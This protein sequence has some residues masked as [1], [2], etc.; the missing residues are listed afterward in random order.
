MLPAAPPAILFVGRL[1]AENPGGQRAF[2]EDLLGAA[3]VLCEARER[4]VE[5][6][7]PRPGLAPFE[8]P[9]VRE[10]VL[11]SAGGSGPLWT[12]LAVRPYANRQRHCVLY[13]PEGGLPV[14]LRIPGFVA[15]GDL[16]PFPQAGGGNLWD[17]P[18]WEGVYRRWAMR[19]AVRQSP[20]VHCWSEAVAEQARALFPEVSPRR[21]SPILPGVEHERWRTGKWTGE[22]HVAWASLE[23][24][25]LRKPFVLHTAGL[26]RRENVRLLVQ[27]FRKFA[28]G[29]PEYQMALA[30]EAGAGPRLQ[31]ALNRL[32]PG[33]FV[34][35]GPVSSRQKALLYQ[36]AAFCV[37]ASL[38]GGFSAGP[39]EAMA[40]GCPVACSNAGALPE[41]VGSAALSFDPRSA[42][43]LLARMEELTDKE[44]CGW[45]KLMGLSHA[46]NFNWEVSAREWLEMADAVWRRAA[47]E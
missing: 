16:S 24:Q 18:R 32:P 5:V 7:V 36:K 9:W 46:L 42:K 25:G 13:D 45:L 29:H 21:F 15:L 11:R 2:A 47:M 39:L 8:T 37:F 19:R 38:Y 4:R 3:A 1:F 14:G 10:V 26:G 30:G 34:R 12:H 27:A 41:L 44:L 35:L 23:E 31:E 17:G 28:D 20:L 22:D 33:S 40:A 6:L 43:D